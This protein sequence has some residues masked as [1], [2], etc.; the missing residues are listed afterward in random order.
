MSARRFA[1][2]LPPCRPAA[3]LLAVLLV[4]LPAAG[5]AEGLF[6][7]ERFAD[8]ELWQ[9]L[10]FPKIPRHSTYTVDQCDGAPCLR[11]ESRNA[12]SGLVLKERFN[13][14]DY[15]VLSW[16]WKV[17]NV[18]RRGDSGRREGDDAPARLYVLFAYNPNGASPARRIRYGLARAV[19]GEYPPHSSISYIWDNRPTAAPFLV[20]A[21]ADE[22]RMIPVSSGPDLVSTWQEYRMDIVR[23]YRLA[24]GQDPPQ[25]ASL[26][27][28]I[29]SDDTGESATAWISR[30]RLGRRPAATTEEKRP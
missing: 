6:L 9:P 11:M 5:R 25:Q 24:F 12:A 22:A 28:M 23:D 20:N 7:D 2:A 27:V 4:L 10:I 19:Y 15:P 13:V 18:Y 21:Y 3:L 8:L 30:I 26:A 29:D 16:R 1:P 14:Y 17:S